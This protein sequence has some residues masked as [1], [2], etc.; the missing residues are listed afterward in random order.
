MGRFGSAY[1]PLKL[2][3]KLCVTENMLFAR[4]VVHSFLHIL[5]WVYD[6]KTVKWEK[7]D[8]S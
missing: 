4:K 5:K 7:G 1:E 2:Y 3:A 6:I 8:P